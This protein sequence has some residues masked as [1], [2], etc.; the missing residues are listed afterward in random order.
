MTPTLV[1]TPAAT[2]AASGRELC[3]RVA[4]YP[5]DP[6]PPA[7]RPVF[8]EEPL[9]LI[10]GIC[11]AVE[12]ASAVPPPALREVVENLVHARFADALV[13]VLDDGATVRV[14]DHGPGIAD[15]ERALRAGYTSAGAFERAVVRGVGGGLPLARSVMEAAGGRLAIEAN[16]GGGAAVT[17]SLPPGPPRAGEPS[18]SETARMLMALLLEVGAARADALARELGRDRGECGRELALLQ[19]RGL[20]ARDADGAHHLTDSGTALLAT[21]F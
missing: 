10:E 11:E 12:R 17:L 19:Y 6:A 20:V 3:A 15:P 5:S 9:D 16:L 1:P 7:V 18:C 8:S 13:S 14:C 2:P 21:L 4:V